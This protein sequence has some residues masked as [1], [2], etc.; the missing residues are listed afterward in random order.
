[1]HYCFDPYRLGSVVPYFRAYLGYFSWE[2]I[3]L[4]ESIPTAE[5][6]PQINVICTVSA[7]KLSIVRLNVL[8]SFEISPFTML[9]TLCITLVITL[10]TPI[11]T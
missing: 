8:F 4:I 6:G 3:H 10:N 2:F 5:K 9:N 7:E 1:M 11:Q